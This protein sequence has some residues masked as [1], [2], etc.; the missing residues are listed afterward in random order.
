[1]EEATRLTRVPPEP[2][3]KPPLRIFDPRH[4]AA[5][6]GQADFNV[7]V[8]AHGQSLKP[9]TCAKC[10]SYVQQALLAGAIRHV[11]FIGVGV[12]RKLEVC[13]EVEVID[14]GDFVSFV[15]PVTSVMGI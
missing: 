12:I 13:Y 10:A 14:C 4:S 7:N 9:P 5:D 15:V 8:G 11:N 6:A 3:P 1:M 2:F